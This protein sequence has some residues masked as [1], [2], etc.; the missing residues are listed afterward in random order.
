MQH[1][2]EVTVAATI[3]EALGVTFG[4]EGNSQDIALDRIDARVAIE[5]DPCCLAHLPD[6]IKNVGPP[7]LQHV[8]VKGGRRLAAGGLTPL[9][10][11]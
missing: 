10:G 8:Q 3:R 9:G 4:V 5:Q 7:A 6:R 1:V 11:I 2:S